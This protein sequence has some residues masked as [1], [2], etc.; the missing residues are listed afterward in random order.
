[1]ELE[2]KCIL[3]SSTNLYYL[4]YGKEIHSSNNIWLGISRIYSLS[5]ISSVHV[6]VIYIYS[7]IDLFLIF[8]TSI[9]FNITILYQRLR[10]DIILKITCFTS[11]QIAC[12][13]LFVQKKVSFSAELKVVCTITANTIDNVL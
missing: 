11:L 13:F 6:T 5:C 8:Y 10:K 3:N 9:H 12:I 1:M 7:M 2:T 4:I